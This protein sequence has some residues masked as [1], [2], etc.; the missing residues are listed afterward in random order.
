MTSMSCL[1]TTIQRRRKSMINNQQPY[2]EYQEYPEAT[3][4]ALNASL[5]DFKGQPIT[6][7]GKPCITFKEK[8]IKDCTM[9]DGCVYLHLGHVPDT[10]MCD[11]I[12]KFQKLK[13]EQK[14]W[15][16]KGKLILPKTTIKI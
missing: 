14:N 6:R 5:D 1:P 10:V 4:V 16:P 12:E 2:F 11:L 7:D 3:V 13:K 9:I 8:T 15:A